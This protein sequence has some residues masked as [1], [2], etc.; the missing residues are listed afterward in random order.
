MKVVDMHCDT[1]MKVFDSQQV[2][3]CQGLAGNSFQLD[4]EKMLTGDYLLQNFAMYIDKEA[5]GDPYR[6]CKAMIDCYYQELELNKD[7]LLPVY[8]YQDIVK[9]QA[10]GKVSSMLTMEEGAPVEGSIEKLEEFYLL[11]VRM[12]TLTWNYRNELGY[13]NAYYFDEATGLLDSNQSG[14]TKNGIEVVQR[15]NELGMIVDVSHG[16]DQ[17]VRDVLTYTEKPFVA[18]HSD[19][20]AIWGH[21]RNLTDDLIK[22]IAERGGVIGMNYAEDFIHGEG[23]PGS[24]IEGLVQHIKHFR[25]VGGIDCIGLG[26]DFDGIHP[27]A[28]LANGSQVQKLAWAL[29]QAGFSDDE[30]EKIFSRN[31]LRLY[32]TCLV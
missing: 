16:S 4:K 13:P 19:A 15:M 27:Y 24:I 26:S 10:A 23:T 7:W 20:R 18:S 8:G 3:E 14:L 31:V 5:A 11:G 9:N 17:L 29:E 32:E 25:E 6:Y 2:G 1:V 28:E 30:L 12:M 22:A 21:F